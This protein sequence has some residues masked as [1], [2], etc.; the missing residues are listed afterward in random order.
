MATLALGATSAT[1]SGADDPGFAYDMPAGVA[2]ADFDLRI[3]SA[4]GNTH[5]AEFVDRDDRVVR[6]ITAGKGGALTFTNLT[7]SETVS[8]RSNGAVVHTSYGVDGSQTVRM[9]G[10][11][12][13]ILFP[14]DVPA[15]PSTTLY[16]GQV[17]FTVDT[18][19]S[20]R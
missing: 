17:A 16:V 8:F 15:G 3:E 11:T 7:T 20:S 18:G 1:A 6:S 2:C 10:H 14:S 9:N 5:T 13:L 12:V 4:G 19:A